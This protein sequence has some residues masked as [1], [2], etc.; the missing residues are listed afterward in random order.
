M[1]P[2]QP[3]EVARLTLPH[4]DPDAVELTQAI[5]QAISMLFGAYW[6]SDRS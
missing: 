6:W 2:D 1:P 4:G 3:G 5:H